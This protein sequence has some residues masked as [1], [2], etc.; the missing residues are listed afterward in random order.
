MLSF[1]FE[2]EED[3]SDDDSKEHAK[4]KVVKNPEVDTSFL[5]DRE[6]EIKEQ[7]Q[8]KKLEEEFIQLQQKL[9]VEH[10]VGLWH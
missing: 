1:D 10:V 7:Q 5:P 8:R 4:K 3:N 2:D 9:K 6:R